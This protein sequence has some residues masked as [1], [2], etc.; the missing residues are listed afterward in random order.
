MLN[1]YEPRMGFE[2]AGS[3]TISIPFRWKD[4]LEVDLRP[5]RVRKIIRR[6]VI[7]SDSLTGLLSQKFVAGAAP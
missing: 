3:Y 1:L 2:L 4:A 7:L 6:F 5:S